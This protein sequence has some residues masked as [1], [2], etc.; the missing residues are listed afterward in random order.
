[1]KYGKRDQIELK[2][3]YTSTFLHTTLWAYVTAQRQMGTDI[4]TAIVNF[5]GFFNIDEIDH[6][7]LRAAYYRQEKEI[8]RCMPGMSVDLKNAFRENDVDKLLSSINRALTDG[9]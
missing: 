6:E 7:T 8:R 4:R 2:Q 3:V 9:R 5:V 1:M